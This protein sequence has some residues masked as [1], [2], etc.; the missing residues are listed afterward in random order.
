MDQCSQ[1]R[2]G[3]VFGIVWES[4]CAQTIYS[5]VARICKSDRGGNRI[6]DGVW[7][8]FFK[9][10]LNCSVPGEFPFYFDEIRKSLACIVLIVLFLLCLKF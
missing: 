1:F 9:A 6:L 7:T 8:S 2:Y 10:R 5:R 3:V 4:L